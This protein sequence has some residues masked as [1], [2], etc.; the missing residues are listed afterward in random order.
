MPHAKLY[1]NCRPYASAHSL[2]LCARESQLSTKDQ[3]RIMTLLV[4]FVE[5]RSHGRKV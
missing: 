3:V 4:V 2:S 1:G 5:A